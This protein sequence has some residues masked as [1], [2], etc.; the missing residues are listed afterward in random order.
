MVVSLRN[1][2]KF[3]QPKFQNLNVADLHF[4]YPNFRE[5]QIQPKFVP[6]IHFLQSL[7]KN[8]KFCNFVTMSNISYNIMITY[9]SKFAY[10]PLK[11]HI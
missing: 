6:V 3:R 10:I 9:F 8:R 11:Y 7:Y 4:I 2:L 5:S 1:S